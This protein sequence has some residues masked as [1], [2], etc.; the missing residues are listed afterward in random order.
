M[1]IFVPAAVRDQLETPIGIRVSSSGA[2]TIA[3][4]PVAISA[5]TPQPARN[6]T[7]LTGSD[8]SPLIGHPK[9]PKMLA[10]MAS[11]RRAGRA[12]Q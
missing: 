12:M 7:D 9:N 6:V 3:G 8:E 2:V 5:H 4:W 1:L 10:D 11:P